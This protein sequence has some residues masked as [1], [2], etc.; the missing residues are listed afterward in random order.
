MKIT[1]HD[2]VMDLVFTLPDNERKMLWGA[3]QWIAQTRVVS[4]PFHVGKYM[5]HFK[6]SSDNTLLFVTGITVFRGYSP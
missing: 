2:Y 5:I 3:I 6:I 1:Y 4:N